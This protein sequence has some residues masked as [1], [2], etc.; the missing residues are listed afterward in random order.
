MIKIPQARTMI[1]SFGVSTSIPSSS[2]SSSPLL[3]LC[4]SIL[5]TWTSAIRK[6]VQSKQQ[7]GWD[8]QTNGNVLLIIP[9]T[10]IVEFMSSNAPSNFCG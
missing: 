9:M 2:T 4:A 8:Y 7:A 6:S 3:C 1:V 5:A 10:S